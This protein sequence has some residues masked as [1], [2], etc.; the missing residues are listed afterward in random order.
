M[1][2][3]PKRRWLQFRLSTWFALV[4][5]LAWALAC[6]PYVVYRAEELDAS[7]AAKVVADSKERFSES[8]LRNVK[9]AALGEL[10]N[11][12]RAKGYRDIQMNVQECRLF[13]DRP[14]LNPKLWIPTLALVAFLG[15][16]VAWAA[17]ERR[18][19]HLARPTPCSHV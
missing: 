2:E 15:W 6:Q 9:L 5:I 4:A 16:K 10:A 12:Y 8:A 19:A 14:V 17:V 1:I 18:R 3:K 13:G 7:V 11:G